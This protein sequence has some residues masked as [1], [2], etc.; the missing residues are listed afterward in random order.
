MLKISSQAKI[1]IFTPNWLGDV[2]F[3]T[4][5]LRALKEQFPS[6]HIS[7][8]VSPTC[9]DIFKNQHYVNDVIAIS[10]RSI[11]GK[12]KLWNALRKGSWDIGILLHR[13]KTRARLFKW[14]GIPNR[15]GYDTNQRKSLLSYSVSEPSK[16]LHKMD[17]LLDIFKQIGVKSVQP[18]YEYQVPQSLFS[19]P[20]RYVVFHPGANWAPKRWPA[21]HYADLRRMLIQKYKISIVITGSL[22][23]A[24]LARIITDSSPSEAIKPLMAQ[25]LV[26]KTSIPELA[27]IFSK[28]WLVV[29]GD[30]GPMHLAAAVGTPVIAL[31]GPTS[32]KLNG[33]RGKGLTK[34][35]W[36]STHL[37]NL[38]ALEV[39]NEINSWNALHE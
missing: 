34:V 24:E 32:P 16:D 30:T 35:I 7:C 8:I 18:H 1:L 31:Y 36:K 29:A 15:M 25:V 33:P 14:A 26:G 38:S 11:V 13:S 39:F 20:Q 23:D 22:Q 3:I 10:D 21:S 5:G 2:L 19:F 37:E 9:R 17:Y 28:A 12:L 6:A 27:S 4:P